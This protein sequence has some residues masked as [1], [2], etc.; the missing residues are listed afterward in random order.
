[1]SGFIRM[2]D[3]FAADMFLGFIVIV[4]FGLL[5]LLLLFFLLAVRGIFRWLTRKTWGD[6][7]ASSERKALR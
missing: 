7:I 3:S 2:L 1:M 4:S 6:V 5:L